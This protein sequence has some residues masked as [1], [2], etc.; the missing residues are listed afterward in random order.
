MYED[1]YVR[2]G[3]IYRV[4]L[5]TGW[6]SEQGVSRPA[7]IISSNVGNSSSPTVIIAYLTTKDHN[8]GIHYGP[9][10][11]T[12]IPS[13]VCCEQLATVNKKRITGSIMGSLSENEM[14]EVES[15]LDEV[16]DLGYVDDA[17]LKEKEQ[18]IN[19][20]KLQMEELKSEVFRLKTSLDAK[21]DEILTRDVEIAVHKRMYE[22]AVGIIAAMRAEPD[23]PERPMG[24][25]K[26]QKV[27]PMKQDSPPKEPVEPKLVDIN[28]ATFSQLRGV[29]FTNSQT[30]ATINCR[31]Y[32]K[33]EDLKNTPGI[34]SKAYYVLSKRVCCVPVKVDT[35]EVTEERPTPELKEPA[36][37]SEATVKVN[38]NTASA[39]EIHVATGLNMTVCYSITG[40]RKRDGLYKSVND[41][42]NIPKFTARHMEK[43]GHLLEV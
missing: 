39:G 30:L 36:V 29:G 9:T 33:L 22:K 32:E 15:R 2:R 26:P 38:V 41:L 20:L 31:P 21:A 12:G 4:R 19:V 42:L 3:E 18:E 14:R 6:D 40:C 13:Y 8:I 37:V 35:P 10:K 7:L 27:E 25:P 11:A 23:L 24:P 17:P 34:N 1:R 5:D 28:T 16:L 43:Y